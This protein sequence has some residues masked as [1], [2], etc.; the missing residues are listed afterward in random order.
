MSVTNLLQTF[1]YCAPM[2]VFS[3]I[4]MKLLQ[5]QLALLFKLIFP[6]LNTIKIL[7]QQNTMSILKMDILLDF[8]SKKKAD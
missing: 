6:F 4:T 5:L 1:Q 3:E 2:K 8:F 7:E